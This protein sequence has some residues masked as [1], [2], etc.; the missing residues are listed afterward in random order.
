MIFFI[1]VR[2]EKILTHLKRFEKIDLAQ[3]I[4]YRK[5]YCIIK[6]LV[7]ENMEKSHSSIFVGDTSNFAKPIS[8]L[9]WMVLGATSP[10]NKYYRRPECSLGELDFFTVLFSSLFHAL[11]CHFH[12][13]L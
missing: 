6:V 4:S 5:D 2:F 1:V 12:V 11:F 3:I 9:C 10:F 7:V 8:S 13:I